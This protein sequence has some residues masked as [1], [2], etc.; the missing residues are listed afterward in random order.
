MPYEL[1]RL[2][3]GAGCGI[4]LYRF[5]IIAFLSAS[6]CGK[7]HTGTKLYATVSIGPSLCER[8]G[9]GML[10]KLAE[11]EPSN[12]PVNW[13]H[14]LKDSGSCEFR[15]YLLRSNLLSHLCVQSP[16][17]FQEVGV[18]LSEEDVLRV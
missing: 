10:V 4:R 15:M 13:N 12:H 14:I 18:I 17:S 9:N 2:V 8:S 3:F 6:H 16:F 7:T 1:S 5:L 11:L